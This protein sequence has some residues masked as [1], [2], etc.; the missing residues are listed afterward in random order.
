MEYTKQLLTLDQQISILKQRGLIIENEAEAESTLDTISYFRLAGYW[1]LME[2][3]KQ[4]HAF[5]PDSYFSQILGLYHF[6][7]ELRMLVFAAIQQIE[8]TVLQR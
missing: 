5:K 4:N 6:D 3:D 1:R 7:E 8:V 2:A